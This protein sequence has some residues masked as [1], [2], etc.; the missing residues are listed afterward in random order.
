MG[1]TF[2]RYQ[3]FLL[4]LCICLLA[5]VCSLP[6]AAQ[7]LSQQQLLNSYFGQN[8]SAIEVAGRPDQTYD[9]LKNVIS[10][11]PGEPLRKE[12][13]D[14]SI[15][16]LEK[17]TNASNITL[18]IEP[19]TDGIDITFVL[20]P[21]IYVGMYQFPGALGRYDYSR[22]LQVADYPNQA[23]YSNADVR[24]AEDAL[25]HFFQQD[26]YFES[27]V[28][29]ETVID[30]P[31]SLVNV[32]FNTTLGR[33][34]K[35]GEIHLEGASAD[36][37]A[38]L[39]KKLRSIR[40]RMRA[41]ALKPGMTFSRFRLQNA[42][43]YLESALTDQNYAAG[44]VQLV[45]AEYDPA[46][47]RADVTFHVT[48]GPVV[49][50]QTTGTKLSKRKIRS[51]VPIYDA[52]SIDTDLINE[53]G[54]SIQLYFQNKGYFDV[55]VVT[56][57][58]GTDS[59]RLITYDI[60][61]NEKH[62]VEAVSFAGNKFY[63]DK[64]LQAQVPVQKAHFFSHG[65][66]TDKMVRTGMKNLE[67]VYQSAGYSDVKVVPKIRREGGNIA[68]AYD[69]TEGQRDFVHDLRIEGNT[70]VSEADL[71]PEGM[72]LGPGKPYSQKL[73]DQDRSQ[74][75]ARYLSRG[76]L[77][78]AFT[79]TATTLKGEKHQLSVVY[80]I[81]EGPQVKIAEI[82][83][84]GRQQSQPKLIDRQLPF[85]S[86]DPMSQNEMMKSETQLYNLEV[87][88][89]AE[90]DPKAPVTDATK[91]DDVVV[92]VHERKRNSIQYGFG[93]E[94]INRG[95]S[96]PSGTVL[97]PGIPPV[98]LP[99]NFKTS[100]QTFWGPRG[101]F[102]YTRRNVRGRAESYTVTAYAARLD[103]RAAFTYTNPYFHWTM[104]KGSAQASFE[105][106]AENPIFTARLG[107]IG[108]QLERALN[109][110]KTSHLFFRYN[111]QVTR[112][113]N[114]LIPEL[115]PPNQLNVRLST[116][117]AS[118]IHDTRDNVLDAHRGWYNSAEFGVNPSWL[119]SNFS[120][121]KFLGQIAHYKDIGHGIVWANSL[122]VGLEEAYAGSEVPVS[123]KFFTGGAS[124]LRGFPL[125]GAGPQETIPACG[126]PADPSTCVK[127]TVPQ[128]GN[129]LLLINSELRFPLNAIK[130]GL[131]IV[132]FYDGGNVFPSVGFHDFTALYTNSVGLGLRYA[133]PIGPV[134]VD[135]GHNL[136]PVPGIKSTQYFITIGQ[137]F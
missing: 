8:V 41:S 18:D 108:Y 106:N 10:I 40:A 50:V 136:N 5:G 39:N 31:H 70:T 134:R 131:G 129:E 55:Q 21:A 132:A 105:R 101:L 74:I 22:L 109:A 37:T 20:E 45:S 89:W 62:K 54:R 19:Q 44:S 92:K 127:I 9:K 6:A 71:T 113:S 115:V 76:Y 97:V 32:L 114:L 51:L 83:T 96:V 72:K 94:V 135:V 84:V 73:V 137:A 98:G 102:E 77:S 46:T 90:V 130:Q 82:I 2:L 117:S 34:A 26:G 107:N 100:Q 79:A 78:P 28:H 133:T 118:Y 17:Q 125:N 64:E 60:A 48:T 66:Y 110:K 33:R 95:G 122:R 47:N 112:I 4:V 11:Q 123:Q 63:S 29:A 69:I 85:H 3:W 61:K 25:S 80:K 15:A 58:N 30:S 7:V 121:A 86:G 16:E 56:K 126:N 87:F 116:L 68:V 38:Y 43:R 93:F 13:L 24:N 88:D 12:D 65:K 36:E 1:G 52:N 57:I 59:A 27:E 53:G 124:T 67:A 23:P 128:G 120:F 99:N 104:W 49:K 81:T 75:I 119:G 35:I 91:D 14:S 103:Q 111:F 42:T